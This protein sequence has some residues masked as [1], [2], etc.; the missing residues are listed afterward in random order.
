MDWTPVR[1]RPLYREMRTVIDN[2]LT[3]YWEAS[4]TG[5]FSRIINTCDEIIITTFRLLRYIRKEI[6]GINDY[7]DEDKIE[8]YKETSDA[9]TEYYCLGEGDSTSFQEESDVLE[10]LSRAAYRELKMTQRAKKD[11]EF[12][13]E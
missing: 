10:I 8:K 2:A 5:D 11:M 12:T 6:G 9:A 3:E 1:K 4:A 7:I 13:G